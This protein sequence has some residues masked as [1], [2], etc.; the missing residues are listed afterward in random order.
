MRSAILSG[1][2]LAGLAAVSVHAG[3]ATV[4]AELLKDRVLQ[5]RSVSE[6]HA[7]LPI[8]DAKSVDEVCTFSIQDDH[9][10]VHSRFDKATD[11]S[12]VRIAGRPNLSTVQVVPADDGS[13][14]PALLMFSDYDFA[15]PGR[16]LSITHVIV[17]SMNVQ[18]ACDSESPRIVENVSIV[19]THE[20]DEETRGIV[21]RITQTDAVTNATIINVQL[22]ADNFTQLRE[23]FPDETT[24]Y[25]QPIF[26]DL[27]QEL[28]L[29]SPSAERAWQV[30]AD[31]VE[32]DAVK[33]A[34]IETL[35][36]QLGAK[37]FR[38]RDKAS[39][40][41]LALGR[42]A[43]IYLLRRQNETLNAEQQSRIQAI[44]APYSQ[45][46]TEEADR[47]RH[48]PQFLLECL[49]SEDADL[50]RI[51]KME[52]EK[53]LKRTVDFDLNANPPARHKAVQALRQEF[54]YPATQP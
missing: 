42:P 19:Q 11:R 44:I 48:D 25:L 17:N 9:L 51:A 54:I 40:S 2:M 39:Q 41:L 53:V 33:V 8:V 23:K 36:T 6:S 52:L 30:L 14:L 50:R 31:T 28:S 34:E 16:A 37:N 13:D 35:V 24:Q 22:E 7:T 15:R 38:D 32:L 10:M 21:F 45:L 5:Q 49:T 46:Q 3:D 4:D 1:L 43:A 18:I 27:G 20:P 29:F 12:Q 47:L 26:R